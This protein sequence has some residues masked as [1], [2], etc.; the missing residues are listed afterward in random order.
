[1]RH[2]QTSL[3]ARSIYSWTKQV[4]ET[5]LSQKSTAFNEVV[6]IEYPSRGVWAVGFI[7]G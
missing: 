5:V 3:G 1:M 4:F 2:R 6:L 7:T